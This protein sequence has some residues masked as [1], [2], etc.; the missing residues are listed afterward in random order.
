[1]RQHAVCIY[2]KVGN[3]PPDRVTS[4][5]RGYKGEMFGFGARL[6]LFPALSNRS[7]HSEKRGNVITPALINAK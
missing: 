2:I 5:Q 7:V 1:M 3:L 4:S 6:R